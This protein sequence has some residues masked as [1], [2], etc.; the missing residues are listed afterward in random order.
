M[1]ENTRPYGQ[2]TTA[3][4]T[5]SLEQIKAL[6]PRGSKASISQRVLDLVNNVEDDGIDAG[7]MRE[8]VM[9]FADVLKDGK[10][11]IEDYMNAV[12]YGIATMNGMSNRKAYMMVF[13]ER[14][15]HIQKKVKE[16]EIEIAA[17][18]QKSPVDLDNFVGMYNKG[19]L[20]VEIKSRMILDVAIMNQP[21][22]AEALNIKINL[23]RGHAAPD[24]EG[25][26]Q[27]V[28]PLI[29]LQAAQ[30]VFAATEMPKDNTIQLKVGY[31]EQALEVQQNIAD[32]IKFAA[33]AQM[34]RFKAGEGLESVQKLHI[35]YE[36]A[37]IVNE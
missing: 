17:G 35:Q 36:E 1:G 24:P 5:M 37:E 12:K 10:Y 4:H 15:V 13:P 30:A 32:Q 3:A 6:L 33:Q 25:K 27:R 2:G 19:D 20:V 9:S 7:F 16:R 23:M 21:V 31:D 26:P 11:P 14:V 34:E 29:Q 22:N 8:K 28:T 18:S